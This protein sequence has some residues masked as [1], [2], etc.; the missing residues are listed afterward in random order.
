MQIITP[1]KC[2][3]NMEIL[4]KKTVMHS[5]NYS[6]RALSELCGTAALYI[7]MENTLLSKH[8][9]RSYDQQE[10]RSTI[11]NITRQDITDTVTDKQVL[12][13]FFLCKLFLYP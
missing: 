5:L 12:E 7:A 3:Q 13:Q 6:F 9:L 4:E 11:A 8:E 1:H 10:M 2:I